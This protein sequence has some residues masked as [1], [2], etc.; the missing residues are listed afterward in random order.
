MCMTPTNGAMSNDIRN[1]IN[2]WTRKQFEI[3][4]EKIERLGIVDTGA[5][6]ESFRSSIQDTADGTSIIMRF[7]Q[8]G[9]YQALGVGYGYEHDNCG[10]LAFLNPDY[11]RENRLDRRRKVG[12]A[13]GGRKTSGKPRERRDWYAKKL[14]M[15]TMAMVE[16]MARIRGEQAVRVIC[17]QLLDTRSALT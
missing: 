1:Y 8:Y 12:P 9:I 3:W 4:K 17:D 13:W 15:S 7:L 6:H 16:D 2:A 10:D 14:Y 11:R 5:L